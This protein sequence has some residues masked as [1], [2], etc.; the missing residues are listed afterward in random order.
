MQNPFSKNPP[1]SIF[2]AELVDDMMDVPANKDIFEN[3]IREAFYDVASDLKLMEEKHMTDDE[4]IE[5]IRK[6]YR[7]PRTDN[8]GIKVEYE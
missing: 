3:V 1:K 6:K 7:S 8:K 4:I 2:Q 5:E